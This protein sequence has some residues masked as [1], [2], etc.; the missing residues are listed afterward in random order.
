MCCIDIVF[1]PHA[2]QKVHAVRVAHTLLASN[3]MLSMHICVV[4]VIH[5]RRIHK[6]STNKQQTM[7]TY[8]AMFMKLCYAL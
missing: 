2:T 4:C 5:L 1:V 6:Y 7:F 8:I 3:I